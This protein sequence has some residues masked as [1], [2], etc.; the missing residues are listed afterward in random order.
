MNWAVVPQ[1]NTPLSNGFRRY[2][3]SFSQK[4]L[5][6]LTHSPNGLALPVYSGVLSLYTTFIKQ[7]LLRLKTA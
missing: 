7:L 4:N 5:S 6:T 1:A 2:N 3:P